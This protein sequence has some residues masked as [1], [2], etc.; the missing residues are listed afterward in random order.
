MPRYIP[1][2]WYPDRMPV[3]ISWVFE[4]EKPA[5]KH[6]FCR[7][8]GDKFEFEDGTPARFWG[9]IFN[10]ACCFP[11]HAYAEGVARR[12][13]QAGCNIVRFHQ[14]DAEW[15]TPNIFRCRAGRRLK[16]TRHFDPEC[17]ERHDYL[18]KCLKEQG[19]Y[20]ITDIT[21]YR[22][23]KSGDGVHDADLLSDN[24]KGVALYAP[25][26]IE[27]Q[28][29]YAYNYWNHVNQYT[30]VAYKD[31]PQFVLLDITNENDLFSAYGTSKLYHKS[32][33]Y[34]EDMFRDMFDAW[35][36]ENGIDY[37]AYGCEFFNL[38]KPM[39]DF[40]IYL[41]KKYYEGM[42]QFMREEVGL[43][44]PMCGTNWSKR[45]GLVKSQENMDF[46]DGHHYYYD[47]KWGEYE[48][49]TFNRSLTELPNSR[50]A[51]SCATRIH[52]QP[53]FMTEWDMPW[54]NSYRAEA[55]IWFPAVN[56]L[57]GWSGMTIHTYAYGSNLSHLD[58]L[59][60][61]ASSSTIGSVPYREGIFTCWND[62][63]KFGL[64]Y[65]GAL[66][67]RRG[68]V[69]QAKKTIGARITDY[70]QNPTTLPATA[71]EIHRVDSVLDTTDV[72]D[73]D[74][75]RP[76]E[77]KFPRENPNKI[78]SD[79]GEL[80]RD[81]SKRIGAVDTPMTKAVYGFLGNALANRIAEDAGVQLNGLTVKCNT[82]FATIAIS[83]LTEETI[84]NSD[85]ILMTTVGRSRSRG[86]QFDGEK[87]LDFGT[88]PI[89]VEVIDA[90]IK[91]KTNVPD[92]R[93]WSVNSDGYYIGQLEKTYE[94]GW[95]K[96]HVGPNYPGMYYL[97][98]QE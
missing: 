6:G 18:I 8:K 92:L 67:M 64:F 71:M 82:D 39:I 78:V 70:S 31:D 47:W 61:E 41:S 91:L 68:D 45:G 89:E 93:I 40:R 26:M 9:V 2:Y 25:D 57:Q 56:L 1:T 44:I 17:M 76:I 28:K 62:P 53:M 84:E 34:Y 5:G 4:N 33:K 94:D 42:Y 38:D 54:P 10:G 90:E 51:G 59:G 81:V 49:T 60:K 32:S 58:L 30:G 75:I 52:G 87:L 66:M 23:F 24:M 48:K 74:D 79:T 95:V 97:I 13:A 80:W 37:D 96:F 20:I 21:T 19:I 83:S 63:S 12:L 15:A 11:D 55:P 29:E 65:H 69:Q 7:V 36:K 16:D 50:L 43:K 77:E 86:A 22:K 98:M 85:C 35:L 72:S 46:Q 27:L 14:M 88:G 3:D 73:L